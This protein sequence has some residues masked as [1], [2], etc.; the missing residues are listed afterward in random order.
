MTMRRVV[1]M[2][3]EVLVRFGDSDQQAE[4]EQELGRA[5]EVQRVR[6]A[7]APRASLKTHDGRTLQA[8]TE[9]REEHFI[10]SRDDGPPWRQIE[11]LVM[12]GV[13]IES[14]R[15]PSGPEAA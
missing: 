8:G 4:Y 13:V 7:V 15:W 14:L 11:R 3:S 12:R 1:N 6:F 9:V 10:Y 5:R 2:R